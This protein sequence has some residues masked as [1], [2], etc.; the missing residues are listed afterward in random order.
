MT[1]EIFLVA[2]RGQPDS[3]PENSLEGFMHALQSGATYLETDIQVTADSVVV[4]SHNKDLSKLTGKNISVMKNN[5]AEFKDISAGFP[6]KFSNRFNHCRIATLNQFSDLLQN[7]P[8]VTCF[9]EIK[10]DSLI[11][12]GNK[13]VDLVVDALQSIDDQSVL[14]SHDYDALVY[15]REKYNKPV[16]WILPYWSR[17]N[18]TKAEKLSPEYLFVKTTL[19][20]KDKKDILAGPWE[21]VVYTVNTVEKMNKYSDLGVHIIETNCFSELKHAYDADIVSTGSK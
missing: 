1:E 20:P 6:G 15:A 13:V 9:I 18:Q 4:L 7:W 16:G 12:F 5:Y 17:V 3:F 14:I 2:H 19:C 8:K 11:C 10:Q 21:W